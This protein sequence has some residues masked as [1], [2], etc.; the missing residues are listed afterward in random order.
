M[1]D[2]TRS[3]ARWL[4]WYREH[5]TTNYSYVIP[6][7]DRFLVPLHLHRNELP[8]EPEVLMIGEAEYD[9]SYNKGRTVEVAESLGV[10]CP[11]TYTAFEESDIE[12]ALEFFGSE[13]PLILK[14]AHSKNQIGDRIRSVSVERAENQEQLKERGRELLAGGPLLVQEYLE[15]RGVGQEFLLDKGEIIAEFQHERVHE[16]LRGGGGSYRRAVEVDPRLREWS[17]SILRAVSWSGVAMVEYLV[18]KNGDA[19][20]MEINGRWWGSLPLPVAAGVDFPWIWLQLKQGKPSQSV[21]RYRTPMYCRN[22]ARDLKWMR[23]NLQADRSDPDLNTL[24]LTTVFG[25]V[26]YFLTGRESWDEL[27]L[28]DVQPG[29]ELFREW[30]LKAFQKLFIKS[31]RVSLIRHMYLDRACRLLKTAKRI[32]V[33]CKGNVCRSPFIAEDLKRI[34]GEEQFSFAPVVSRGFLHDEER[35]SSDTAHEAASELGID[36]SGHRSRSL[37][38]DQLKKDDIYILVDPG[39]VWELEA[40]GPGSSSRVIHWG[41]LDNI[42]SG[43]LINDPDGR[44]L[45]TYRRV[46]TR[47]RRINENLIEYMSSSR[48]RKTC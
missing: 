3:V 18:A 16:P 10:P 46:Y 27:T 2:S 34:F 20:L 41:L 7:S 24:P 45:E 26:K 48:E 38:S 15:G 44:D 25:E 37:Y 30:C 42:F 13:F 39:H 35:R 14:P 19:H 8:S 11:R 1:I 5:V 23:A 17:H 36:L 47:I 40:M 28:D 33:I 21:P 32:V 4:K 43:A 12:K 22:L 6:I 29:L 9:L 31:L